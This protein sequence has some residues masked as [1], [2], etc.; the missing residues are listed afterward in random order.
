VFDLRQCGPLVAAGQTGVA[1]DRV[2]ILNG[3]LGS[4]PRGSAHC[5][6]ITVRRKKRE[7]Y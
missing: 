3:W 6:E 5:R 1:A 7:I 4:T 2:R